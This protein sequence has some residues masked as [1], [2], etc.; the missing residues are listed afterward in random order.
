MSRAQEIKPWWPD[1]APGQQVN[2]NMEIQ[3]KPVSSE[4]RT[5]SSSLVIFSQR[6]ELLLNSLKFSSESSIHVSPIKLQN[7][8]HLKFNDQSLVEKARGLEQHYSKWLDGSKI[9]LI[10]CKPEYFIPSV[11]IKRV[12]H[13]QISKIS[14]L[15]LNLPCQK[16]R[17]DSQ[18]L[19]SLTNFFPEIDFFLISEAY[20]NLNSI[21]IPFNYSIETHEEGDVKSSCIIWKQIYDPFVKVRK[22]GGNLSSIKI[23]INQLKLGLTC[24]YRS[25]TESANMYIT[26]EYGNPSQYI[27]WLFKKISNILNNSFKEL[28][29]GDLNANL[30]DDDDQTKRKHEPLLRSL[31]H[32]LCKESISDLFRNK[33][34]YINYSGE[35]KTIDSAF[36][37][38]T[39]FP[40][41]LKQIDLSDSLQYSDHII[42]QFGIFYEN[43]TQQRVIQSKKKIFNNK[44]GEILKAVINQELEFD[45]PDVIGDSN[46]CI[47]FIEKTIELSR[48][49][50]PVTTYSKL[51]NQNMLKSDPKVK[52]LL[53]DRSNY[54][55]FLGLKSPKI[56][57]FGLQYYNK[58]INK[59]MVRARKRFWSQQIIKTSGNK[60]NNLWD[61]YKKFNN[62]NVI[63]PDFIDEHT[64][65]NFFQ[66]LSWDYEPKNIILNTR[67][68]LNPYSD[69][70]FTFQDI[71]PDSNE[72]LRNIKAI[73]LNGKN[74][75]YSYGTNE[76]SFNFFK[77]FTD[78]NWR[79]VGE[80][81]NI[82]FKEGYHYT[83]RNHKF[84]PV[85]KKPIITELKNLRPVGVSNTW[86]NI[87]E[88]AFTKQFS[89]HAEQ[90]DYFHRNQY[91]FRACFSIGN[92]ISDLKKCVFRTKKK[93]F[94]LIQ[95]DLSN[96][97]G[98]SD[99]EI[100]LNR[101]LDKLDHNSYNF[102]K[103]FLLQSRGVV[104]FDAR[105]SDVFLTSPRGFTQGATPSPV[106]FCIEMKEV[107]NRVSGECFSFADDA[108]IL[109]FADTIDQLKDKIIQST[110]QFKNFCD[111][112]NIKLNMNKTFYVTSKNIDLDICIEN[113][114]LRH[115]KDLKI[116]GIYFDSTF[117][118]KVHIQHLQNNIPRFKHM[119]YNFKQFIN[120]SQL[121]TIIFS[122]ILGKINHTLAYQEEWEYSHY[123]KLQS[124][125][126]TLANNTVNRI[127]ISQYNQGRIKCLMTKR[128]IIRAFNRKQELNEN[129]NYFISKIRLPQ[130]L[131]LR[132][133][134]LPSIVNFHRLMLLQKIGKLLV[135]G[136][137]KHEYNDVV[138]LLLASKSTYRACRTVYTFKAYLDEDKRGK[139]GR[140]RENAPYCWIR[141]VNKLTNAVKILLGK[142]SFLTTTKRDY[143]ERCQHSEGRFLLCDFCGE[144]KNIYQK[145]GF[146]GLNLEDLENCEKDN[147]LFFKYHN[148]EWV[149]SDD[150]GPKDISVKFIRNEKISIDN[151]IS[152][153]EFNSIIPKIN[154]SI[155][156]LIDPNYIPESS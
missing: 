122:L 21:I 155:A 95:T 14:I 17:H 144:P 78:S 113:E 15:Y 77:Y 96:A 128:A 52:K 108:N 84:V 100:I 46:D 31:F 62:K 34:T 110:I 76:V 98:S 140:I 136:R 142:R 112:V 117:S 41:E 141:E 39:H 114:Q 29:V 58:Q 129:G 104:N 19:I 36:T 12:N 111:D 135:T 120:I 156:A 134:N 61:L 65:A 72:Y 123:F 20:F 151:T 16:V 118:K 23:Q 13:K 143:Y 105:K 33:T 56:W 124:L 130:W 109:V 8:Y 60:T 1:T 28:I 86:C 148:G 154:R 150:I 54:M 107:H 55:K 146:L 87:V 131:L 85:P 67:D 11:P 3:N 70:E 88:K 26:S 149:E 94:A 27:H 133:L 49:I 137:P 81:V 18:I 99:T 132:S 37:N 9:D 145:S 69:S 51:S 43:E 127:I 25:P 30:H 116:L 83:F 89:F 79:R 57:N 91:G 32:V 42:Q 115:E 103:N 63:I 68:N 101:F 45:Y 92:L 102:L 40:I 93:F 153:L 64:I 119:I 35:P 44:Q 82:I 75:E 138:Q 5:E 121:R 59:E 139:L 97:F 71:I 10:R 125:I 80:I 48:N 147:E 90:H 50:L 24:F 7:R 22:F 126:N 38:M 53:N 66:D 2:P 74:S 4:N 47:G 152:R 106:L 73:M 6:V